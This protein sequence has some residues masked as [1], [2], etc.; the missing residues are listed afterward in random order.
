MFTPVNPCPSNGSIIH[1]L[2]SKLS[3]DRLHLE[4]ENQKFSGLRVERGFAQG[5]L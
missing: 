2:S 1:P 5:T 3:S 4:T